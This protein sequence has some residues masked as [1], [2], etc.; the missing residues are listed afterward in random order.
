MAAYYQYWAGAAYSPV[1]PPAAEDGL[2]FVYVFNPENAADACL[3]IPATGY[4]NFEVLSAPYVQGR[5]QTAAP[6]QYV[7]GRIET[8]QGPLPL[9]KSGISTET[10]AQF[11]LSC[12]A[13]RWVRRDAAGAVMERINQQNQWEVDAGWLVRS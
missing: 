9:T 8:G 10:G 2:F 12:Q 4:F 3:A 6:E 7:N 1:H 11:Q 5:P 13:G